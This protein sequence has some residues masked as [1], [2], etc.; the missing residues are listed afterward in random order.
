ME[1]DNDSSSCYEDA[2]STIDETETVASEISPDK[3]DSHIDFEEEK[4]EFEKIKSN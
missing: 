4:D 3:Y 1:D 2:E